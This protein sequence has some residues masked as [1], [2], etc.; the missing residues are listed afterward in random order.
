VRILWAQST[1]A[2]QGP[3]QCKGTGDPKDSFKF[4]KNLTTRP[5]RNQLTT[6]GVDEKVS[7]QEEKE[8][9]VTN[10]TLTAK[11]GNVRKFTKI[12]FFKAE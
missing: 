8:L 12:E 4:F 2:G 11:V 10:G 5:I 1:Q 3:Q 9:V 6:T 7:V